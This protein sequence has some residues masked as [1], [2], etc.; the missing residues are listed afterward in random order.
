MQKVLSFTIDNIKFVDSYLFLNSSLTKL[1]ETLKESGHNFK[2]FHSFFSNYKYRHLLL[3]KGV[4]PYSYFSSPSVLSETE[5]P[6]K[7]NFFNI[8]TSSEV[9]S[10]D[11]N[12]A[13]NVWQK[14]ICSNFSD[15]VKIYQYTDVVLLAEVFN[16]FRKLSLDY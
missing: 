16:A 2:A 12:H 8:L 5:L 7:N 1:I 3:Q 13:L 4:F 6:Q 15:Y 14:F 9:S 10:V 11:Y